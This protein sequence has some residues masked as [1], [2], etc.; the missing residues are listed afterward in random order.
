MN[1]ITVIALG[2]EVLIGEHSSVKAIV[3]A[4]TIR[5]GRVQYE[6]TF[7][8]GSDL[9][10]LYLEEHQFKHEANTQMLKVNLSLS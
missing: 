5:H 9:T 1:E 8:E 10:S 4:I 3:S 6:V 7:W 2:S